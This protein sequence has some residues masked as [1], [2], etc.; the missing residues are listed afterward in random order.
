MDNAIKNF[1]TKYN[2]FVYFITALLFVVVIFI[3]INSFFIDKRVVNQTCLWDMA[4]RPYKTF[5]YE[6]NLPHQVGAIFVGGTPKKLFPTERC[7]GAHNIGDI[8]TSQLRSLL[9]GTKIT[10]FSI[11]SYINFIFVISAILFSLLAGYLIFKNGYV[12]I[13]LFLLI[14]FFRY[15]DQG[16]IYGLPL[17][18]AYAVFNP[19]LIFCIF[20][21]IILSF[22]NLKK[23]HCLIFILAGFIVGYIQHCRTSEGYIAIV[24]LL[25]V[26]LMIIG[27]YL[28]FQRHNL[29]K[30]F[31]NLLIIFIAMY[32][33]Y[34]GYQKM[35]SAFKYDR[36][37][38]FNFAVAKEKLMSNQASFHSLYISLFRY[39]K[40]NKF[41]DKIGYEAV[42]NKYP[43]MKNRFA[44]D[45]NYVELA[46]S[47]EYYANIREIY[48]DYFLHNPKHFLAYVAKSIY[49]YILFLP[50]YSW[51]GNKSAH[52]YLPKINEDVEIEPQDLAP[53]FKDSAFNW[54]INLKLKYLPKNPL[55]LIYFV[56]AYALLIE[57]I[58]AS[59]VKFKEICKPRH[60]SFE[61]NLPIYLLGCM[62]IYFLFT[63]IVRI[64]IPTHGQS[65]VVTF[66]MIIIYNL[67]RIVVS[68]NP[69]R[70]KKIIVPAWVILSIVAILFFLSIK[71][72]AL[73]SKP[74]SLVK[75]GTFE[76]NTEGWTAYQAN[77]ANANN[78]EEEG[79]L[80][81][82]TSQDAIGYAYIGIP[83]KVG[84]MYKISAYFR[85]GSSH[86][87]QI[88]VGTSVD[89]TTLYYSGV[90]F[91]NQWTHYSGVFKAA[92][93]IT[94]ITLV[95]LS[96]SKEKTCFFDSIV[97]TKSEYYS[98]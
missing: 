84:E 62:L 38:K 86:D 55:F 4:G 60:K 74:L 77:L 47:R 97:V 45:I 78:G 53:D 80:R 83:T 13:P 1:V 31:I 42:Y 34:L 82:T 58:Y 98:E 57:A 26:A 36:A 25:S 5:L 95:N 56:C 2:R 49:D 68:K 59:F 70:I 46:K 19:P 39:E 73:L 69:L 67:V 85:R 40:P 17:R 12:S 14:A 61:N 33:G 8:F 54:I 90:L 30:I 20:M 22:R 6:L 50:Y 72:I 64:L 76:L 21:T 87:G 32:V 16:L 29:K 43:E 10:E 35:I 66:N 79:C 65:A 15:F 7:Y 18:H 37:K 28:I 48:F 63:S 24:S 3:L 96:D 41:G 51:T 93:P 81:V 88:K 9:F 92:T 75:N 94:Y 11:A 27:G 52:A 89:D 44:A 71:G 23:K 91:D